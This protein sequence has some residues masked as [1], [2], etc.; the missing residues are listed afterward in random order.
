MNRKQVAT[1]GTVSTKAGETIKVVAF[2]AAGKLTSA[3]AEA[4]DN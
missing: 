4:T 1:G 2:G 3:V